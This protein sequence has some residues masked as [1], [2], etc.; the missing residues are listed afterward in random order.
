MKLPSSYRY[1]TTL[2][3]AL[4]LVVAGALPVPAQEAESD[5]D[6]APLSAVTEII[7]ATQTIEADDATEIFDIVARDAMSTSGVEV[8]KI[9]L[10]NSID[11]ALQENLN[12]EI[13]AI[14]PRL[15]GE[16]IRAE[17]SVFDPNLDA[18]IN[19]TDSDTPASGFLSGAQGGG[20]GPSPTLGEIADEFGGDVRNIPLDALDTPL[21][22]TGEA[23]LSSVKTKNT[24]GN[25]GINHFLK[26]GTLYSVRLENERQETTSRFAGFNP[27]YTWNLVTGIS[28]PLLQGWNATQ[29]RARIKIAENTRRSTEIFVTQT[30][31]D[32]ALETTNRYWELV[33]TRADLVIK[34]QSL[35]LAMDLLRIKKAEVEAGVEAPIEII[36]ASAGVAQREE[37]VIVAR[38]AIANSEDN[39]RRIINVGADPASWE[40]P[41]DPVDMPSFVVVQPDLN[42][43]IAV[44]LEKEPLIE[45]AKL[46]LNSREI[47][48]KAARNRLLPNLNVNAGL[49]LHGLNDGEGGAFEELAGGDFA[50]WNIGLLFS[51]PLGNNAA[52][53]IYNSAQLREDQSKLQLEDARQAV[54]QQVRLGVRNIDNSRERIEA[55]IAARRLARERLESIQK[56]YGVGLATTHDVLEFQDEYAQAQVR[57]MRAVIDYIESRAYLERA[58]GTILES[59]GLT[60]E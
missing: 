53:S 48:L 35:A 43:S 36:S 56:T 24:Y 59:R 51:Y 1:L 55:A 21:V 17:E 32:I 44:A 8:L 54:I 15:Q 34:K 42:E 38:N 18:I 12:L 11:R 28:Q 57:E 13:Q 33:F 49:T 5:E 46:D 25:V 26:T 50:T 20:G 10:D 37:D 7:P 19:Y 52:R 30:A 9:S 31:M 47:A 39:L 60:V 4:L 3:L 23:S 14:N 22:Q 6:A 16:V 27:E 29:N 41:L 45:I 58:M 2:F 40:Q